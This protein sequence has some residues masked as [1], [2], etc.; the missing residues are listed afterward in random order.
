MIKELQYQDELVI[1]TRII[2]DSFITVAD[3]LRLTPENAPSN[4]AFITYDNV[5]DAQDKGVI[6]FG[7]Y[8]LNEMAGCIAIEKSRD[9]PKIFYIE[10]LGVL[11]ENRHK[12]FGRSLIDYAFNYV[13]IMGG[14]KISIAVI[15]ENVVLKN[16]YLQYGFKETAIKKFSHLPFTVCFM[17][18]AV[19]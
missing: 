19:V 6:Y 11:P 16:W 13:K 9:N 5:K 2:R 1:C 15:D 18:K 14:M 12:G 3:D 10:R 4:P 7:L 8:E 17:E